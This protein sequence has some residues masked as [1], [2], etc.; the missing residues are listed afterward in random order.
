MRLTRF[1]MGSHSFWSGGFIHL[2]FYLWF[3]LGRST[4]TVVVPK[5]DVVI[6]FFKQTI[7]N[8]KAETLGNLEIFHITNDAFIFN[9]KNMC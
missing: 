1:T 3:F 9:M 5:D 8:F 6:L 4:I 2:C 7:E